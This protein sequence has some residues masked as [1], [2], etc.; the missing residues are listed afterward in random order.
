MGFCFDFD[1]L[2]FRFCF[3]LFDLHLAILIYI[4]KTKTK[5]KTLLDPIT[6]E[7]ENQKHKNQNQNRL[8]RPSYFA[9]GSIWR[10]KVS[11]RRSAALLTMLAQV[12][13]LILPPLIAL[14]H[15]LYLFFNASFNSSI[16]AMEIAL[17][18]WI[19]KSKTN[20]TFVEY[21]RRDFGVDW[22]Y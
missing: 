22:R 8:R 5:T 17:I 9:G 21:V 7:N 6:F 1:F 15:K 14:N 13:Y 2:I 16:K 19:R 18:D 12:N 11:I 3:K 4:M 10:I 20:A